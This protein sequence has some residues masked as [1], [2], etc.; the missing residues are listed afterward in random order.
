[1]NGFT[2]EDLKQYKLMSEYVSKYASWEA[3]TPEL[4]Q[5]YRS[6]VWFAGIEE[7]MKNSLMEIKKVTQLTKPEVTE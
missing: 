3:K 7:K 1:M 5:I 2:E 6:L 4:I